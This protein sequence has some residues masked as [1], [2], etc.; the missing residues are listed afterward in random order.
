[1]SDTFVLQSELEVF[2]KS[3][4]GSSVLC[5]MADGDLRFGSYAIP[6][7]DIYGVER[8]SDT[9]FEFSTS[10][11]KW[12]FRGTSV[13][14]IDQWMAALAPAP[15]NKLSISDFTILNPI[16]K[17]FSGE[18]VLAR[19][20]ESGRLVALKAIPKDS[21]HTTAVG[22]AISERNLLLQASDP[23]VAKLFSTFQTNEALVLV[24]EFVEGGD[25]GFHLQHH[26]R[27]SP[28][29]VKTYLAE[30][31]VALSHIHKLGIVFRDLKPSN[32]LIDSKGHLKLTDFGLAK[33]LFCEKG[34][35]ARTLCG[36]HEYLA[37]EMIQGLPYGQQVDWWAYG[38]VAYQLM[39]GVLPYECEN[40]TKLYR[41]IVE[42]PLKFWK[43][44][45]R[46]SKDFVEGLLTK[47]PS[48]RLGCGPEGEKEIFEHPFF[49]GVDW[50]KIQKRKEVMEFIP[51]GVMDSFVSSSSNDD[52]EHLFNGEDVAEKH[53]A[54]FSYAGPIDEE[55]LAKS[56]S[57]TVVEIEA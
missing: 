35:V 22:R 45:P 31:A 6:V 21:G 13:E 20:N 47:N 24:L 17:G 12:R 14:L 49:S 50:E 5:T 52:L 7:T 27:F 51:D 40:L 44:I 56:R 2:D 8:L 48:E 30:L 11:A 28:R 37:P 25:L 32:I 9:E 38:I 34:G 53:V 1:M 4:Q 18:V 19:H 41:H 55:T 42:A 26:R 36:T 10:F 54:G 29:T 46:Q 16:G 43:Q 33:D 15:R 23:F 3:D 57:P 39:V